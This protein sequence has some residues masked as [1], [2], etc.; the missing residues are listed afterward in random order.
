MTI[1]TAAGG[2]ADRNGVILALDRN[3]IN[4]SRS[5]LYQ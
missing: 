4:V 3:L 1:E 2:G 5:L